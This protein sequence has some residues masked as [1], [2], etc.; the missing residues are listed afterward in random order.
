MPR[1]DLKTFLSDPKHEEER[2]FM[3]G[4]IDARIEKR[5]ADA[6]LKKKQSGGDDVSVWDSLFGG[7]KDDE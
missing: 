1:P 3:D 5:I 2:G 7:K 6:K 4:V